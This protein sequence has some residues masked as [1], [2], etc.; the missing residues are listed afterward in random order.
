M[1]DDMNPP[2]DGAGNPFGV[3]K[4]LHPFGAPSKGFNENGE[5]ISDDSALL[6]NNSDAYLRARLK[7]YRDNPAP[8]PDKTVKRPTLNKE[9]LKEWKNHPPEEGTRRAAEQTHSQFHTLNS[10][11]IPYG[12]NHM[13]RA[14]NDLEEIDQIEAEARRKAARTQQKKWVNDTEDTEPWNWVSIAELVGAILAL[15]A[16]HLANTSVNYNR[17]IEVT[18]A[19]EDNTNDAV[20][21]AAI[22]LLFQVLFS[23]A[24]FYAHKI[25]WSE[26]FQQKAFRN[27][28]FTCLI[29]IVGIIP[30]V[31]DITPTNIDFS[32]GFDAPSGEV[33]TEVGTLFELI[34]MG[35]RF[36]AEVALAYVIMVVC[37]KIWR[38]HK[39]CVDNRE[40]LEAKATITL[41]Q[42]VRDIIT[43]NAD[44]M[45]SINIML[46]HTYAESLNET[47][48]IVG[49]PT[50]DLIRAFCDLL[51][52]AYNALHKKICRS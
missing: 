46:R 2:H 21:A 20:I 9:T 34:A 40:Y 1:P 47:Y 39:R 18:P 5:E 27:A 12:T 7:S 37:L 3:G 41:C 30:L 48:R 19:L 26:E 38:S 14:A 8:D 35:C 6:T 44:R 16:I 10:R 25:Y 43:E 23:L 45:M 24:L 42:Q 36:I 31:V 13:H 50:Q 29:G 28:L 11:C 17:I 32:S 4:S 33:P 52:E 51:E 22:I 49:A 15:I